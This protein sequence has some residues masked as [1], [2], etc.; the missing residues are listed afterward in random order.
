M[1]KNRTQVAI[2]NA[3]PAEKGL[4]HSE[5][6]ITINP[7]KTFISRKNA[8]FDDMVTKLQ[9]L[10]NF[11]LKKS[12]LLR[13]L[14][15]PEGESLKSNYS[16]IK[17]IDPNRTA[18]VEWSSQM[19]RLHLHITFYIKHKTKIQLD[20]AKIQKIASELLGQEGDT[21]HI[22]IK[23]SGLNSF[24]EYVGKYVDKK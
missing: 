19:H 12:N 5:M 20:R 22:N 21:L 23:A 4:K 18:T 2:N 7:N 14:T 11:I 8:G 15:F 13:L 9:I 16:L 10:G 17:E 24:K 3:P 1:P 6:L